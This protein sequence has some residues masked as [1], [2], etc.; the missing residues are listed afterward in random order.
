MLRNYFKIGWRNITRHKIY[1]GINMLGLAFGICAC[2]VIY[3]VTM[4]DFS[5]EKFHPDKE[6]IYRIVG[7]IQTSDGSTEFLN[8]VVNNVAGFQSQIPGFEAK[9]GF[10]NYGVGV[11]IPDGKNPLKKF[12]N[13]IPGSYSSSTII[14]W[15]EYFDIFKYH[16]LAGSPT[17]LNE[18]FKVVLSE[19]RARKYFGDI[20]LNKM[21]GKTVIYDDSLRTTVSGIVQDWTEN[22]DFGYT[23]FIS[24]STAA[25]SFLKARIP[26]T[27]W[28]SLQPHASM[29]FVKLEKGTTAETI[30]ERFETFIKKNVKF[31]DLGLKIRMWLQPLNDIHFTKDFH[32]GDDGDDF[33]KPYLPT[34]Y[35]LI[36]VALFILIIA[37][38]NFIN[39]S[40]AQSIQRAKEIAVRKVLGSNRRNIMFQFLIETFVLTFFSVIIAVLLVKPILYF[41]KDYIPEGVAFHLLNFSMLLFLL[42]ITMFTSLLAGFYPARILSSYL[43][44]LSLKGNFLQRGIE[45][46][47]LRKALIVFQFTVSLIFII[48]SI[49]IGRQIN[50]MHDADKG[51]NSNAIITINKWGDR[52]GLL[53]V[54]AQNIKHI[55]GIDKSELQGNAPMGFAQMTSMYKYK[56]EGET[57]IQALIETGDEEYI[58]FYQMKIIAGRNL[59]YSDSLKELVV[60]ET[61]AKRI[62]F[63]NPQDA[64]GKLLIESGPNGDK[65]Y[66]IVG[67]VADFHQGSFHDA[68]QPAIIANMPQ[69]KHSVAIKLTA[70]EKNASD[71]K[72]ILSQ[73][74]TQ[75]KK[76]FPENPF[77]YN[78]LNESI[79]WLYG[80]EE[81]TSWLVNIAMGIT[82]FISCMGLFGLAMF[83]A[84]KRTKEV[85][86]RKVLGASVADITSMLSKDF[87][88]LVL[89]AILIASPVAW[90]FMNQWLQ[91]FAYRITISWSVFVIAGLIAILIALITV[92][93]HAIKVATSNPVKSLRTE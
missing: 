79:T 43:P 30:N 23:D 49:I 91:D 27:D 60:N 83:T 4:Y 87:V 63:E 1:T 77:E 3:L 92:S 85:G 81:K 11:S 57:R 8:S 9:A 7:E 32:R 44:A 56:G 14:T 80:Q 74:E 12:D 17:T 20:P 53:K 33:R 54:F 50:F 39:L 65:T 21:I 46:I 70:S 78:F 13:R 24:I 29:A 62:G 37:V 45:K 10:Y 35:T 61:L 64:V 38:V 47:G 58:P 69:W 75:W 51:F 82:I 41:F 84:E 73:M 34:L 6:R 88:V 2:I 25:N 48:A 90:Y 19:N 18:P 52:K 67:V 26:S 71:V 42:V 28:S 31:K 55:K 76:V 15:P 89:V 86:I 40:T 66:P 59:L 5:F 36:G 72:A 68:I 93:T 22:T 16:W